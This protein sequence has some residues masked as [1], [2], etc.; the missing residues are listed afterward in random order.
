MIPYPFD[1]PARADAVLL[2]LVG[3]APKCPPDQSEELCK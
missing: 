2:R 3:A 1:W